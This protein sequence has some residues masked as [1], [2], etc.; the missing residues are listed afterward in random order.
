MFAFVSRKASV[1]TK[2]P[3]VRALSPETPSN[4]VELVTLT[5][6]VGVLGR[7]IVKLP[8][9]DGFVE[10]VLTL[11]TRPLKSSNSAKPLLPEAEAKVVVKVGFTLP[12]I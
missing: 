9:N 3:A 7:E 10:L 6:K 4:V 2:V 5:V 12:V 8:T 11:W 1:S